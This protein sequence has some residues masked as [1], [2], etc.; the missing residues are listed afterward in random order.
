MTRDIQENGGDSGSASAQGAG[1]VSPAPA[2]VEA[3]QLGARRWW[4]L[5]IFCIAQYLDIAGR[6]SIVVFVNQISDQLDIEYQQSTWILNSY[7]ITFGSFLLFFGRMS[8][9]YTANVVFVGGF[10]TVGISSLI[11]SFMPNQYAYYV[12]RALYGVGAAATIPSAF[13]MILHTFKGP[14]LQKALGFF[15]LAGAVANATGLTLGG[16]FGYIHKGGQMADWRWFFRFICFMTLPFAFIAWLM[17]PRTVGPFASTKRKWRH[18]D[19]IG[20]FLALAAL[21]LLDLGLTFGASDGWKTA[22]FLVP[23]LIAWPVFV[24]FFLWEARLP[25]GYAMLPPQTWRIR[26]LTLWIVLAL[27]GFAWWGVIQVAMV[28]RYESTFGEGIMISAV[29]LMPVGIS[30]CIIGIVVPN[31]LKKIPNPRYLVTAAFVVSAASF[32]LLI[33]G[34]GNVHRE[35]W[36]WYFP[37]YII[38]SAAAAIAYL[39]MNIFLMSSVR[40]QEAGVVGALFQTA[41][42]MGAAVA[43][44]AQAGLLTLNPGDVS[45]FA[46]VQASFWFMFGW[47]LCNALGML[48]L[49]RALPKVDKGIEA[50][51]SAPVEQVDEEK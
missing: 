45:D 14:D 36:R 17:V 43:L 10:L 4:L 38:G 51:K 32:L 21:I 5:L 49:Y 24:A 8:D 31:I 30:A 7:N 47:Y 42:Q 37:A 34:E 50:G 1:E 27:S 3:P 39:G 20:C 29:R 13:R 26:N 35:Y 16:C 11:V 40:P 15:G 2:G 6:A 28:E 33:F 48:F 41:L 44:A 19:I 23:F 12:F 25:E 18:L 46:N 22:H 9:L